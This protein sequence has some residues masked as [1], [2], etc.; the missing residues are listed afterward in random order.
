MSLQ[1]TDLQFTNLQIMNLHVLNPWKPALATA[2]LAALLLPAKAQ[3]H[4]YQAFKAQVPFEFRVGNHTLKAGT[5]ELLIVGPGLIVV[6]DAKGRVVTRVLTRSIH[7]NESEAP[8]RMIFENQKGKTWL[9][10]VWMTNNAW[11]LEILGEE[12]A[13]RPN[14]PATMMDPIIPRV[15]LMPKAIR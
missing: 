15:I 6:R 5:Y 1:I 3:T 11:G 7:R 4:T 9:S 12:I 2:L 10:A 14:P 8:P 13:M